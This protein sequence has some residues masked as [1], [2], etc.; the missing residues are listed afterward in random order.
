M[1]SCLWGCEIMLCLSKAWECSSKAPPAKKETLLGQKVKFLLRIHWVYCCQQPTLW[2]KV[3][4]RCQRVHFYSFTAYWRQWRGWGGLC[5]HPCADCLIILNDVV[6]DIEKWIVTVK[7]RCDT[8]CTR[9][10]LSALSVGVAL[11]E[12]FHELL[13]LPWFEKRVE[14]CFSSDRVGFD[15]GKRLCSNVLHCF[16]FLLFVLSLSLLRHSKWW[17]CK[18]EKESKQLTTN[19][20]SDTRKVEVGQNHGL[21]M[22]GLCAEMMYIHLTD[23]RHKSTDD[24]SPCSRTSDGW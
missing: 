9:C 11:A 21:W 15:Q 3:Q 5:W 23:T 14:Y 4:H 10:L 7:R 12:H 6:E 13:K 22:F 8:F 18:I 2:Y 16:S 24:P 20:N 1:L 19:A 17:S